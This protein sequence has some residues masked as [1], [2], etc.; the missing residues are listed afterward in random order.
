MKQQTKETNNISTDRVDEM[1]S[2]D[3]F[4]DIRYS[5]GCAMLVRKCMESMANRFKLNNTRTIEWF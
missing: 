4:S 1:V 3:T 5:S 2:E